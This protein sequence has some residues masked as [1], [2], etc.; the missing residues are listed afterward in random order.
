MKKVFKLQVSDD[1]TLISG[2]ILK[3]Y[4]SNNVNNSIL[5]LRT[6]DQIVGYEYLR[7]NDKFV[8]RWMKNIT[9]GDDVDSYPLWSIDLD[10]DNIDEIIIRE[11]SG[12]KIYKTPV[13]I[14][15]LKLVGNSELFHDA[16]GKN[17]ILNVGRFYPNQKNVGLMVRD[18]R[19]GAFYSFKSSCFGIDNCDVFPR[20]KK[21]EWS[22]SWKQ[23]QTKFYL[24]KLN[25]ESQQETFAIRTKIGFEFYKF[26]EKYELQQIMQ[27]SSIET[28]LGPQTEK[29]KILF[30]PFTNGDY[31]D[32]V[33]LNASGI[34]LYQHDGFDFYLNS[35]EEEM[36]WN[37]IFAADL[38]GDEIL[39]IILKG[40]EGVAIKRFNGDS[41]KLENV[42]SL[43]KVTENVIGIASLDNQ[44]IAFVQ[45]SDGSVKHSKLVLELVTERNIFTQQQLPLDKA[46]IP[47]KS[48]SIYYI[49]RSPK[50][51]I[52]PSTDYKWIEQW[53]DQFESK[54]LSKVPNANG[55][56]EFN[57]PLVDLSLSQY[58]KLQLSLSFS[59]HNQEANIIGV[60]WNL[61]LLANYIKV[62][63]RCSIF[64][65]D[66]VYSLGRVTLRRVVKNEPEIPNVIWFTVPD[67]DDMKVSYHTGDNSHWVIESATERFVYG[68]EANNGAVQVN[69]SWEYS[70]CGQTD[71]QS[72]QKVP[73]T[74]FL[75]EQRDIPG[76][77]SIFYRY[78]VVNKAIVPGG[79]E[80]THSVSLRSINDEKKIL[81][82]FEYVKKLD[83]EV[84]KVYVVNNGKVS[85]PIP[86]TEDFYLTKVSVK[87]E[88]FSQSF[89]FNY[90]VANG[91]RLLV[92]LDQVFADHIYSIFTFDYTKLDDQSFMKSAVLPRGSS[93]SFDHSKLDRII[94]EDGLIKKFPANDKVKI[95]S[96]SDYKVIAYQQ[97]DK[98]KLR[99]HN[100]IDK[101]FVVGISVGSLDYEFQVIAANV[102]MILILITRKDEKEI[103]RFTK[104]DNVWTRHGDKMIFSQEEKVYICNKF[105]AFLN[106]N[107][108]NIK[109][110]QWKDEGNEISENVLQPPNNR[111]MLRVHFNYHAF[112][113]YD[114]LYLIVFHMDANDEWQV[115][116]V[117]YLQGFDESTRNVINSFDIEDEIKEDLLASI[118]GNLLQVNE[119]QIV[120]TKLQEIDGN[121]SIV[122]H[123]MLLNSN[124]EIRNQVEIINRE[125]IY[126]IERTSKQIFENPESDFLLKYSKDNGKFSLRV[127]DVLAGKALE[128]LDLFVSSRRKFEKK[129]M[130]NE[131]NE[132][133]SWKSSLKKSFLLDW[134]RYHARLTPVGFI[135]GDDVRYQMTGSHWEQKS[136]DIEKSS[137]FKLSNK[138]K[139]EQPDSMVN[140]LKL[141]EVRNGHRHFVYNLKVEGEF[142]NAFPA[143]IAYQEAKND[144]KVLSFNPEGV[145][146]KARTITDAKLIQGDMNGLTTLVNSTSTAHAEPNEIH[147][148]PLASLMSISS[149]FFINRKTLIS[150][151]LKR[152]TSYERSFHIDDDG[153][154]SEKL[155][156]IPG[157]SKDK[158]GWYEEIKSLNG[159]SKVV[160]KERKTFFSDGKLKTDEVKEGKA[161]E[162]EKE[163]ESEDLF[164]RI[165]DKSKSLEI[166]DIRP[167]KVSDENFAFF[168]FE[169]YEDNFIG[170][171]AARNS[172][173][174]AESHVVR[175]EF[176]LTGENFLRLTYK[177]E[178]F[179]GTIT[180]KNQFD[181][182][183]ASCWVRSNVGIEL[184]DIF[185]ATVKTI[186]HQP[187]ASSS[188]T[189]KRQV[190][191]WNY[192]E[193]LIDLTEIRNQFK[194]ATDV[195]VKITL[196]IKNVNDATVDIDH[197]KF[198]LI[199]HNFVVEVF[200]EDHKS[201]S[202]I[203]SNGTIERKIFNKY[204]QEIVSM[205][206]DG[207]VEE[208][209]SSSQ[210]RSDKAFGNK[211]IFKATKKKPFN[212]I[213]FWRN[214][215]ISGINNKGVWKFAPSQMRHKGKISHQIVISYSALNM[216]SNV[217][218]FDYA[219]N[220]NE[221]SIKLYTKNVKFMELSKAFQTTHLL[222]KDQKS[223]N[224]PS[225]GEIILTIEN[226][227]LIVW[228]DGV[229]TADIGTYSS[230]TNKDALII[231]N[232]GD[233]AMENFIT[234]DNPMVIVEYFNQWHEPTQIVNVENE[235]VANVIGVLH[236]S[237]GRKSITTK[238]TTVTRTTDQSLL[239]FYENFITNDNYDDPKSVWL[240]HHI[241]GDVNDLNPTC[242]G[243]PYKRTLFEK[244][245]SNDKE[246]V[247]L[248]G[249]LFSVLGPFSKKIE[250]KTEIPFLLNLFPVSQG[251]TMYTKKNENRSQ[252]VSVFDVNEK[253][254]ADYVR[255]P[256]SDHVF[257]INEY[258]SQGR[259]VK[260]LPPTYHEKA[261]T[262]NRKTPWQ[263]GDDHLTDEEKELQNLYGTNFKYDELGNVVMKST[264]DGGIVEYIYDG[265]GNRKFMK[266]ANGVVVYFL[267]DDDDQLIESG[268]LKGKFE[269]KFLNTM[270][271]HSAIP[272]WIEK[273]ISQE[274]AYSNHDDDPQNRKMT[275]YFVTHNENEEVYDEASFDKKNHLVKK[276]TTTDTTKSFERTYDMNKIASLTYPKESLDDDD[277]TLIYKYDKIGN[278]ISIGTLKDSE[279]L[280]H[281]TYTADGQLLIE[282]I[283]PGSDYEYVRHYEYQTAGYLKKISDSFLTE[284]ITHTSNGYGQGGFGDGV[285]SST[286]FKAHW[287]DLAATD[288]FKVC[289]DELSG[290]K[291]RLFKCFKYLKNAGYLSAI[292]VIEKAL[293]LK[294]EDS[295]LMEC[296]G[297]VGY[298]IS[299]LMALKQVPKIYGHRYAYG[300][301][302]ELIKAKYFSDEDSMNA[303]PIRPDSFSRV[304][305]NSA[306]VWKILVNEGFVTTDQRTNDANNA[307]G[308]PGLEL[309]IRLNEI[310]VELRSLAS[311][312]FDSFK[313]STELAD[314]LLK[315]I[316]KI[317]FV[318][319]ESF[320][321]DILS[322]HGLTS[323][324]DDWQTIQLKKIA[325]Q[326]FE[327]LTE[328]ALL[329][330]YPK[331]FTPLN[332]KVKTS[333]KKFIKEIPD[334][335]DV[336]LKHWSNDLGESPFDMY[337]YDID[338]NGNHKLFYNGYQ[339]FQLDYQDKTNKISK[340]KLADISSPDPAKEFAIKHDKNGNMIKA[341]HKN[342][343]NIEYFETTQRTKKI[344]MTDGREIKF[345]YDVIG[346]RILKQVFS[347]FGDLQTSIKYVRDEKGN[348]LYDKKTIYHPKPK[349]NQSII[350]KYIYGPRGII[351]FIRNEEF[352]SVNI[353]HAGSV[354][355]IIKNGQV[356]AT[357]DYLP[358]GE[359]MRKFVTNPKYEIS[360]LFTGQEYD[361]ETGLYNYHARLYDP[362]IGRFYQMDPE[363]QCFSP[364]LYAGNSPIAF[365]DPDGQLFFLIPVALAIGGAFLG[366]AAANN[367][368]NPMKWKWDN[369]NTYM[370]IGFG[371]LSK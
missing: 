153:N 141:F 142:V 191:E 170:D 209:K 14:G 132:D 45:S 236:D 122:A 131:I 256:G 234:I 95:T 310:E 327:K 163:N 182:F 88:T 13:G 93:I 1:K 174:Y 17:R 78:N 241:E 111:K 180:P 124:Y 22:S 47:N 9:T 280:A 68:K 230:S 330:I 80:Y 90:K 140:E 359:I 339:R 272:E 168:G 343:E 23:P 97:S 297:S 112:I 37:E 194:V 134:N 267:Y 301:H 206:Q 311:P 74:W 222:V 66:F 266:L 181:F 294:L 293:T 144:I 242:E 15:E 96:G 156:I 178:V 341:H 258:N 235:N 87:T 100:G 250:S 314:L 109:T 29:E 226:S 67:R 52:A 366:G 162:Y 263:F 320:T 254:V 196:E 58:L 33:H 265:L 175:K 288:I 289:D 244:N 202:S 292:G 146:K 318:T 315:K 77:K 344:T 219:L 56:V 26:N 27:G 285:M 307:T 248:P 269:M 229:L 212:S 231:E 118:D 40:P 8:N 325:K 255:V 12:L 233:V 338:A 85:F 130:L 284:E 252:K 73:V 220:S 143:Y 89:K 334:I 245:P 261:N 187:I 177:D 253:K 7:D 30:G 197:V 149:E 199:N 76:G 198:S 360:Y 28:A 159:T 268:H 342:I 249:K 211:L 237:L 332:P 317:Q 154:V 306:E 287:A 348:V 364:Y 214:W 356:V 193:I 50:S 169:D 210:E 276:L 370:G 213:E 129:K 259:I 357:Y 65:D 173:V 164:G 326:A 117:Q 35:Y 138:I 313:V 278:L 286:T 303:E 367:N 139:I 155:S 160:V 323:A 54:F 365:I 262:F 283:Q 190:D 362:A 31:E 5:V 39:E 107:G 185:K 136:I 167:Y 195:D 361:E 32:V 161:S 224:V 21:F 183:L 128:H 49:E 94:S 86:L 108:Q 349:P 351:G 38:D 106:V 105:I 16:Y 218:R 34:F 355:L 42:S 227:R 103:L 119:N 84:E 296:K 125:N 201:A 221:S 53:A 282:T 127:T 346:E 335:L 271:N 281:F 2:H 225:S 302:Q 151:R 57:V 203:L 36:D 200:N 205:D 145:L 79:Q 333:L 81:A 4:K 63:Y 305:D 350:T 148:L 59:D 71:L 3:I 239:R 133:K 216:N 123:L 295:L 135:C 223:L 43:T 121:I 186:S 321:E 158:F 18:E 300:N 192:I 25:P 316:S 274:F 299:K 329:P 369:P 69:L 152:V 238:A 150:G 246:A 166:S 243:F 55:F 324:S 309:F 354:R 44:A 336:V 64:K 24:T 75:R 72:L 337:S 290:D 279:D 228:I 176:S 61:Q 328:K 345:F 126:N 304:V 116:N 83:P 204:G 312:G 51:P 157:A 371:A 188:G 251:F 172:W 110:L 247:G 171:Q 208:L 113:A 70:R 270:A 114:D 91:Q 10:G 322:M 319:E 308:K 363:A 232:F 147:I 62:D 20:L 277:F 189:V 99:V 98:I 340:I 165:I 257:S 368:W 101:D 6:E 291:K 264:P 120:L 102:S 115:K 352:L 46:F 353:D 104:V 215:K 275:K 60:G 331:L 82:S 298:E 347:P 41:E 11:K 207:N 92:G 179:V 240:T 137:S 273:E 358:Y 48:I 19:S 217:I 260:I 184:N